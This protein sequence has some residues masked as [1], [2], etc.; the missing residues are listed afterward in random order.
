MFTTRKI[1]DCVG[2]TVAGYFNRP[3]FPS[4][5]TGFRRFSTAAACFIGR[6]KPKFTIYPKLFSQIFQLSSMF[7]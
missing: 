4:F 7:F 6:G 5:P 1:V 2:Q 3:R